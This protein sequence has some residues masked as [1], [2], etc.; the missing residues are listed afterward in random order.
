LKKF[1]GQLIPEE[2]VQKIFFCIGDAVKEIHS[3]GIVHR[4]IKL[5]NILLKADLVIKLADFGFAR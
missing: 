1:Y 5:A 2:A 3:K 4:D